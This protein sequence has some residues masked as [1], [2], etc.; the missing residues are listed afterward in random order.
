M[1]AP[2]RHAR[3]AFVSVLLLLGLLFLFLVLETVKEGPAPVDDHPSPG[4]PQGT[5]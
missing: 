4:M 3:F 2:L 5:D 1:P